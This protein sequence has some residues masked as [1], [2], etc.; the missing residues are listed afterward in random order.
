[1]K[2]LSLLA[3]VVLLIASVPLAAGQEAG[4]QT[5]PVN[6]T[7]APPRGEQIDEN[8]VLVDAQ[9]DDSDDTATVTLH[10][11]T[12]QQVTITDAGAFI[13]GG[14]V[15]QRSA[16]LRPDAETTISMPVT[17]VDG[18]AGVSIATSQTL[19]AVPL[20]DPK[21]LVPGSPQSSDPLI[22]GVAV[23]ALFAVALPGSYFAI[24][25]FSDGE[26]REF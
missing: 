8:T 5:A 23:F 11:R 1:M 22:V 20:D 14:E 18:Y 4:T 25:R 24:Q 7:E 13:Q 2:R 26:H 15:P 9:F 16:T 21:K 17:E 19:Y 10:S 12:L 3:L 6:A